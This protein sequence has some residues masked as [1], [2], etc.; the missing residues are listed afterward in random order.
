MLL[1]LLITLR[2]WLLGPGS[3]NERRGNHRQ[4]VTTAPQLLLLAALFLL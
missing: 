4:A 3:G 1:L 2:F